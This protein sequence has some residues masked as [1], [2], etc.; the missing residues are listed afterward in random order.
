MCINLTFHYEACKLSH[1]H[2]S[3]LTSRR[4]RAFLEVN[5]NRG[6]LRRKLGKIDELPSQ[7]QRRIF[8]FHLT[9]QNFD[10]AMAPN[11][12]RPHAAAGIASQGRTS[13]RRK[14]AEA[15]T[16]KTKQM[17]NDE[18]EDEETV[19]TGLSTT[20]LDRNV[21]NTVQAD[22]VQDMPLVAPGLR[23]WESFSASVAGT[24]LAAL[25]KVC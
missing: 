13:K 7:L 17:M 21:R 14:A 3:R 5:V 18:S 19:A 4:R 15:S 24:D 2:R 20:H 9:F 11:R 23:L 10:T 22:D 16:E 25:T 1:A 6:C 8:V 12:K